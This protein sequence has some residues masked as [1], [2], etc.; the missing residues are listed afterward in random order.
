MQWKCC[1]QLKLKQVEARENGHKKMHEENAIGTS[2]D[3]RIVG[4]VSSVGPHRVA[5]GW[6]TKAAAAAAAT[7]I[8]HNGNSRL[9][10]YSLIIIIIII[11][12]M[13]VVVFTR[14][15]KWLSFVQLVCVVVLAVDVSKLYLI[16]SI[17]STRIFSSFSPLQEK[18]PNSAVCEYY[19]ASKL[20]LKPAAVA[21]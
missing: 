9:R 15:S 5:S 16:T 18:D 21:T 6:P 14:G 1:C 8:H 2:A 7:G 11:S 4:F 3:T 12:C 20:K 17:I 13:N 10:L 19:F